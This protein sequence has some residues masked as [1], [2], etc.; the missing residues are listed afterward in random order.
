MLKCAVI[1][2]GGLG[3]KH[4]GN[5]L[6][7]QDKVEIVALCDVEKNKLLDGVST[8]LGIIKADTDFSKYHFY[9]DAQELLDKE[10]LDF[11]VCAL[12]TYL[13]KKYAVMAME[14]GVHVFSEKPMA[15]WSEEAQEMIDISQKTGKKLMIGQCLRFNSANKIL[16]EYYENEEYSIFLK[17]YS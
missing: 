1:G 10:D 16:K 13:H 5:L 8:N 11:V 15:R 3:K 17:E 6:K 12:P 14:K 2:L 9:T 7:M 4:L